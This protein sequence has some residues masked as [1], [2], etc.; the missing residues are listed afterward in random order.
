MSTL[1]P[2]AHSALRTASAGNRPNEAESREQRAESRE[3]TVHPARPAVKSELLEFIG[4]WTIAEVF[5]EQGVIRVR[6]GI[7]VPE[8][9][10][11]CVAHVR[12]V[13]QFGEESGEGRISH[14]SGE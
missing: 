5:I 1:A 8:N 6:F 10:S 14:E 2:P 7:G 4:A 9:L 13:A 11:S 12:V 3:Q